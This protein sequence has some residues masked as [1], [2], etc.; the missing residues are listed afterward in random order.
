MFLSTDFSLLHTTFQEI[1]IELPCKNIQVL[2]TPSAQSESA[3]LVTL[4]PIL[5]KCSIKTALAKLPISLYFPQALIFFS[6]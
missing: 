5:V 3:F 2:A 6:H 1:M 4:P